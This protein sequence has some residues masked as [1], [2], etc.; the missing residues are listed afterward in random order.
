[1]KEDGKDKLADDAL[2]TAETPDATSNRAVKTASCLGAVL[3]GVLGLLVAGVLVAGLW[4]LLL[5]MLIAAP[6]LEFLGQI[7]ATTNGLLTLSIALLLGIPLLG[8]LVG[9][10][11]S[12]SLITLWRKIRGRSQAAPVAHRP[13]N[14]ITAVTEAATTPAPATEMPTRLSHVPS[15][16]VL[17]GT[18]VLFWVLL[19]G[20]VYISGSLALV[21]IFHTPGEETIITTPLFFALMLVSHLLATYVA[22]AS[23]LPGFG[24]A[25]WWQ[26]QMKTAEAPLPPIVPALFFGLAVALLVWLVAIL[27]TVV[28]PANSPL[29][30]LIAVSGFL[31][32][33]LLA[34]SLGWLTYRRNRPLPIE[35][36]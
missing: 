8:G 23:L 12:G 19:F 16:F 26:G 10:V 29:T 35:A 6:P 9:G 13:D 7:E 28:L 24:L 31:L 17:I 20:G 15:P 25:G 1:M 18:S 32:G 27:L 21:A 34:A 2:E 33:P 22:F 3:G 30:A 11:A 4:L 36:V 5:G 14:E